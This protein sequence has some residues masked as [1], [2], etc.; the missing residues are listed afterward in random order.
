MAT[1]R[2][3]MAWH[4]I[5]WHAV[6]GAVACHGW[7]HDNPRGYRHCTPWQPHGMLWQPPMSTAPRVRVRVR[8]RVGVPWHAVVVCGGS[9]VYRGRFCRRWCHRNATA[10]REK[11]P[12]IFVCRNG[13]GSDVSSENS[14]HTAS[15]TLKV[16]SEHS[17]SSGAYD[18]EGLTSSRAL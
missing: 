13:S 7:Y 8:V 9:E 11:R 1:P 12:I 17:Q 3:P 18:P 4:R 2:H 16:G 10:C 6:G 14:G 5:L 15:T